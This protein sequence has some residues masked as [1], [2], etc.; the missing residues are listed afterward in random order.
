MSDETILFV[1]ALAFLIY[2]SVM[3][4]SFLVSAYKN[5]T[6][7]LLPLSLQVLS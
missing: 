5:K 2:T 3:L 7:Q 4:V 1:F 6:V